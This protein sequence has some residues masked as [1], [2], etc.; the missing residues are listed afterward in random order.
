MKSESGHYYKRFP[1]T[2]SGEDGS[3]RWTSKVKGIDR[4]LKGHGDL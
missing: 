4:H 2:K 1:G 3:G